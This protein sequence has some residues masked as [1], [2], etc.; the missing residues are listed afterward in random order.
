M[1]AREWGGPLE[2]GSGVEGVPGCVVRGGAGVVEVAGS[3]E[4][5]GFLWRG[6]G[7]I[8]LLSRKSKDLRVVEKLGRGLRRIMVETLESFILFSLNRV[9]KGCGV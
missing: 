6:A 9:W 8:E 5:H 3:R 7:G 4:R 2:V 1:R